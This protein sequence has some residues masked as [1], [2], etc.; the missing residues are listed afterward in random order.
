M[1]PRPPPLDEFRETLLG[2][3]D[4][5]DQP[6]L[7]LTCFDE[8]VTLVAKT[9]DTV[10]GESES[11]VFLFHV[12]P[13]AGGPAG[14]VD[15]LLR[16]VSQYLQEANDDRLDAGLEP[17]APLPR[18]CFDSAVSPYERA[19]FLLQHVDR[20]LPPGD[21]HRFVLA[22]VPEAIPDRD[23]HA[24]ILGSL[25][26]FQD[27]AGWPRRLRLVVRDDRASPFAVSALRNAG[28]TGP[29]LYTTRLTVNDFADATAAEA[30]DPMLPPAR[31]MNALLQCANFDLAFGRHEA[32]LEKFGVLYTYYETHHVRELQVAVLYGV[33]DVMG[34]LDRYDAAQ[35][36]FV[37]GLEVATEARS[38]PLI[39]Q[40]SVALADLAFERG[41][42]AQA[43]VGYA[44]GA[45]AA[46]KQLNLPLHA[47]LLEKCGLARSKLGNLAG[48]VQAWSDAAVGARELGYDARLL[49]VLE[50]LRDA[51][52]RA[53]H[54][55]VAARYEGELREVNARLTTQGAA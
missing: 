21:G 23:A 44:L 28:I 9:L 33:G 29:Y 14:Y 39:L 47:D 25:V 20:W 42:F 38:L 31:R 24:R 8:E 11:D 2:F 7:V 1:S 22:L 46:Q 27:N 18:G 16:T 26:P 48:A 3:V 35:E 4:Q 54:R 40:M 43:E 15:G 17:L 45:E 10:D 52:A 49:T 37:R 41:A 6:V 5:V 19:Q 12:A 51:S 32:A 30:A 34:R 13:V 50:R 53:G 55:D 36:W